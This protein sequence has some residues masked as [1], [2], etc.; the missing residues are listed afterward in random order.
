[1]SGLTLPRR[2]L[3]P[4]DADNRLLPDCAAACLETAAHQWCSLCLPRHP[5]VREHKPAMRHVVGY[6]PVR[7]ANGNYIDAMA[8]I[9]KAAWARWGLRSCAHW[10]GGLELWS[11]MAERGLRGAQVPGGPVAEYRVH[12]RS[13][14]E[15]VKDHPDRIR[16]MMD[17]L[18]QRHPWLTQSGTAVV[19]SGDTPRRD[20][21]TPS[22]AIALEPR[23][24]FSGRLCAGETTGSNR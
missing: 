21:L 17:H 8:L 1:M 13:M 2:H 12:P 11:K 7:L 9:S 24:E 23:P 4:L 6:D 20:Y 16:S 10:L 19:L 18:Q 14:I 3:V 5:T 22:E 15:A